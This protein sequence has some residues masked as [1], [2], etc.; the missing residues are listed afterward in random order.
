VIDEA[1]PTLQLVGGPTSLIVYGG[2]RLLTDPTFDPP[3][4]YPRPGT[5]VVLRKLAGPAVDAARVTPFD[6]VLLSHDHHSDNLDQ[7][8]R[9][10]LP[11]A[12]RVLTT[13]AG[14][15]P[16]TRPAWR[17]GTPSS[18]TDPPAGRSGSPRPRRSTGHQKLPPRTAP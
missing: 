11:E 4:E 8:G 12:G 15:E 16:E 14:A 17:P 2:V 13:I 18:S 10:L 1:P 7:A 5:A 6:A 9:E 3:G